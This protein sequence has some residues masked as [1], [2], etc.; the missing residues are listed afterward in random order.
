[1]YYALNYPSLESKLGKYI[2]QIF[3]T[4]G[5]ALLPIHGMNRA[6]HPGM[7][8]CPFMTCTGTAWS[9]FFLLSRFF[10]K[11]VTLGHFPLGELHTHSSNNTSF[12]V[13]KY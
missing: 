1:M 12:I 8:C 10:E 9:F 2:F 4:S 6:K 11:T 3:R 5:H 13:E 7:L